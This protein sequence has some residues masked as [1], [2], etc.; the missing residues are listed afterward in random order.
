ALRAQRLN[1]RVVGGQAFFDRKEV[2]DA[3]AYLKLALQPRDEISLRRVINYPARGIGA[4]TLERLA[5]HAREHGVTLLDACGQTRP[6]S[7]CDAAPIPD[8]APVED[9]AGKARASVTAFC[10]LIDRGRALLGSSG[11]LRAAAKEFLEATGLPD[12]LRAASSSAIQ[13]QR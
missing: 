13:A 7:L 2:K 1:Y 12:D 5:S 3:I 4:T 9:L 11:S 8:G 10:D 6:T